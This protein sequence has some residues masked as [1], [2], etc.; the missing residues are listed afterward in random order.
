LKRRILGER[1][2]KG[3]RFPVMEEKEFVE[4]VFDSDIR[5]QKETYGLMKYF[6]SVIKTPLGFSE[7]KRVGHLKTI[8]RFKSFRR[9][10]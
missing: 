5:S 6:N 4:F 9:V 2:V 7:A 3:I 10:A 8:S 1:I